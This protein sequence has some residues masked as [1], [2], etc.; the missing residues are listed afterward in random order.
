MGNGSDPSG[1]PDQDRDGA[2]FAPNAIDRLLHTWFDQDP[3]ARL[4]LTSDLTVALANEA[5]RELV[6]RRPI[7]VIEQGRMDAADEACPQEL[8]AFVRNC[9]AVPK[10][11]VIEAA[12]EP[13]L[14]VEA[15]RIE[16]A[17]QQAFA[18]TLRAPESDGEDEG[19]AR[20]AVNF[21]LTRTED[22]ILRALVAGQ[23][24]RRIA[25]DAKCSHETV[26][27]HIRNIYRKTGVN[28]RTDLLRFVARYRP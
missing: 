26:R 1:E 3:A 14:L 12:G 22:R 7:L 13:A 21:A 18:L 2:T 4:L 5:A 17:G 11:L 28:S 24:P 9:G 10:S 6:A 25:E 20:I 19:I 23:A 15:Q 27:S 16:A 8:A